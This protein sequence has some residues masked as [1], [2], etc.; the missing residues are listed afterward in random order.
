MYHNGTKFYAYKVAIILGLLITLSICLY[1]VPPIPQW[2]SYH[3]FSDNRT[4]FSITNFSNV[5]SNIGF[6]I[7]GFCGLFI[8]SQ[9]HFLLEK[10]DSI[11]YAVL[12]LS[13]IFVGLGSAYY[14]LNPTTETLFWDRLPMSISFMSFFA[15]IIC[16][17]ITKITGT[18]IIL[19][20]LVLTGIYSVIYW[21]QTEMS[22]A[23]DLRLYGLIQYFP[24]FAIPLILI[25]FP[26]YTYTS[27]VPI[28][29]ALA[30][31]IV[32]KLCEYFDLGI[33]NLLSNYVSGHTL[34]HITATIAAFYI[35]QMLTNSKKSPKLK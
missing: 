20:V 6:I 17:R 22:G 11:P 13:I 35:L 23:G 21:Q 28:F 25:F 33:L 31:Y 26:R 34:K 32:A 15:A 19:P 27:P 1:F 4:F 12:F 9:K 18:Y 24:I 7:V 30:W 8:I 14:H 29:W 16:D 3:H 5:A 2:D 10:H